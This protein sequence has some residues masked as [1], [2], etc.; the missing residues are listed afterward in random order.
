MTDEE[1]EA[2][3]LLA[4]LFAQN[5]KFDKAAIVLRALEEVFPKDAY[6]PRLLAECLLRQGEYLEALR[7]TEKLIALGG[8]SGPERRLAALLQTQAL[9]GLTRESPDTGNAWRELYEKSLALYLDL[10]EE[11]ATAEHKGKDA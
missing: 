11:T 9:W 10:T 1:R 5:G 6:T 3:V 8:L 4:Y 7:M 2:L